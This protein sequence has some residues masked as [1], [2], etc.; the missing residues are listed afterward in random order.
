MMLVRQTVTALGG[1]IAVSEPPGATF[2]VTLPT[3]PQ[4]AGLREGDARG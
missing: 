3:T 1:Q 2:V 4:G